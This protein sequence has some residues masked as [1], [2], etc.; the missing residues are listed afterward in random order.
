[1][2]RHD[3]AM[4][5]LNKRLEEHRARMNSAFGSSSSN[6]ESIP[7]PEPDAAVVEED[8]TSLNTAEEHASA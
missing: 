3:E 6:S 5:E 2:K 7:S 8:K 1:M 4:A